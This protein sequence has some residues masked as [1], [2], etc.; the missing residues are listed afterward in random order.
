MKNKQEVKLE[1][2]AKL[3]SRADDL[4][5]PVSDDFFDR[6]HDQIMNKIEQTEIEKVSKFSL[7]LQR[8]KRFLVA[9]WKSWSLSGL[10]LSLF[11]F[12]SYHSSTF[13]MDKMMGSRT[14]Q[15]VKNE[16]AILQN[17]LKSTD[18]YTASVMSG[19]QSQEDFLMEVAS[20]S[21]LS[22]VA[23]SHLLSE[24]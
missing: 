13:V 3:I 14:V 18:E 24:N 20:H 1:S 9:H 6:M 19:Y 17:V 21:E 10:S 7:A 15:V 12:A 22:G 4:D 2:M 11:L 16:K 5:I 23:Q 8:T